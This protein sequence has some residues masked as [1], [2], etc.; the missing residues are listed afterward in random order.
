MTR[1]VVGEDSTPKR[2][3]HPDDAD[4]GQADIAD[5]SRC[6]LGSHKRPRER[7]GRVQCS[8]CRRH[9][10]CEVEALASIARCAGVGLGTFGVA[11]ELPATM[12]DRAK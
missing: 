3:E 8:K 6:A 2:F 11:R 1:F 12:R 10:A 4:Q 9:Q 7:D 5:R